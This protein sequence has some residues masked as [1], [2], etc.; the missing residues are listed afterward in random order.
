MVKWWVV[1]WL[2]SFQLP[3]VLPCRP[4]P[5]PGACPTA[6]RL[7]RVR[8]GEDCARLR[9]A[10]CCQRHPRL[11]IRVSGMQIRVSGMPGSRWAKSCVRTCR[12]DLPPPRSPASTTNFADLPSTGRNEE[13]L[14]DQTHHSRRKVTIHQ[15]TVSH[16]SVSVFLESKPSEIRCAKRWATISGGL[17]PKGPVGAGS[18]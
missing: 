13:R 2:R 3:G 1:A 9:G 10:R 7:R 18:S 16:E 12:G 14:Q 11:Q 17:A 4:R 6:F 15:I 5:R 8:H